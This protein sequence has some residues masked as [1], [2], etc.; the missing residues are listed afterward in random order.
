M[1]TH[2]H[3]TFVEITFRLKFQTGFWA[4]RNLDGNMDINFRA[5][6]KYWSMTGYVKAV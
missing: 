3:V 1:H 4:L 2:I 5:L 6:W